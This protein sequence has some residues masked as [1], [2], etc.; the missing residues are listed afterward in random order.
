[1]ILGTN[2]LYYTY[3]SN[4]LMINRK[5]YKTVESNTSYPLSVDT[6]KQRI[7]QAHR[8]IKDT[9]SRTS[10]PIVVLNEDLTT[11]STHSDDGSYLHR[12]VI[13]IVTQRDN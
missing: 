1:M 4:I 8:D 6:V 5:S 13:D 2:C 7:K 11:L 3:Y 12:I 9:W 10:F